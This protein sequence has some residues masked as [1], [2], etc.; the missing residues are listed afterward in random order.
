MS[1]FL[2]VIWYLSVLLCLMK[3]NPRLPW[4]QYFASPVHIWSPVGPKPDY[5]TLTY[6]LA[7]LITCWTNCSKT[8][9][10]EEPGGTSGASRPPETPRGAP[11]VMDCVWERQLA[12]Q[13][14]LVHARSAEDQAIVLTGDGH[15]HEA[16][17]LPGS[18]HM[19]IFL[20]HQPKPAKK[21]TRP[22]SANPLPSSQ[23]F[24]FSFLGFHQN[25]P[26][27]PTWDPGIPTYTVIQIWEIP[28][29]QTLVPQKEPVLQKE[30]WETASDQRMKTWK[31]RPA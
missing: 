31:M 14:Q 10:R 6:F 20:N 22:H 16:R 21:Q 13:N 17:L 29:V 26:S 18:D 11:A 4:K 12:R 19:S 1:F 15:Q 9:C 27:V 7:D 24:S 2:T 25:P 28:Y 23:Q 3:T 8:E 30:L 5:A